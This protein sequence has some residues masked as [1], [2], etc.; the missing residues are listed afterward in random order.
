MFSDEKLPS[1]P[2]YAGCLERKACPHHV[3]RHLKAGGRPPPL[4]VTPPASH[5]WGGGGFEH[6]RAAQRKW[7]M[8]SAECKGTR[9]CP[10]GSSS[11]G[12]RWSTGGGWG[13]GAVTIGVCVRVRD[14]GGSQRRTTP[15][16]DTRQ[17]RGREGRLC[18]EP[19]KAKW[20][21][22]R[23]SHQGYRPPYSPTVS[24]LLPC[25]SLMRMGGGFQ[26]FFLNSL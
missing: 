11:V 24:V 22:I 16:E 14:G 9:S 4:G 8:R 13:G 21:A 3:Q 18:R 1:P 6:L 12:W 2:L 25:F 5:L 10:S 26:T 17:E 23:L 7:E 19:D 15:V 20:T